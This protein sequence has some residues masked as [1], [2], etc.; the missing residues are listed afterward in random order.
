MYLEFVRNSFSLYSITIAVKLTEMT[1]LYMYTAKSLI[2]IS[3][4]NATRG[5]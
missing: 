2:L 5:T 4:R 1:K 3:I